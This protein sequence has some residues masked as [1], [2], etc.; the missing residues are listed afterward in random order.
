[1]WRLS[2]LSLG[3]SLI[4]ENEATQ[5]RKH[6]C[7]RIAQTTKRERGGARRLSPAAASSALG[8]AAPRI[9]GTG[10]A[11]AAA[12]ACGAFGASK[13]RHAGARAQP[14]GRGVSFEGR[15]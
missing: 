6:A 4:L 8:S 10:S 5:Q 14:L 11:A 3:A 2:C 15:R 13:R 1:M 12:S 9:A 7:A